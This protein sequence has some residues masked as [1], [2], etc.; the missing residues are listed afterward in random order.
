M[1]TAIG[2]C[3]K[4][5]NQIQK[6]V[7]KTTAPN[8]K[9]VLKLKIN[10]ENR[11]IF[12]PSLFARRQISTEKSS[13]YFSKR[14]V[15]SLETSILKTIRRKEINENRH[16]MV[17]FHLFII[18]SQSKEER[19]EQN[20]FLSSCANERNQSKTQTDGIVLKMSVIDQNEKRIE[21]KRQQNR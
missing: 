7:V 12:V 15:F 17:K 14:I 13:V 10:Q 21:K 18:Q 3:N 1:R 4:T 16:R 19:A 6:N 8:K 5:G 2:S 9:N 20:R 11:W